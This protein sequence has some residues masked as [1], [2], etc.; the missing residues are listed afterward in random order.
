MF[1]RALQAVSSRHPLAGWVISLLSLTCRAP[2]KCFCATLFLA[3]AFP[4]WPNWEN[5]LGRKEISAK[6]DILQTPLGSADL[7]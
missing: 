1:L 7:I 2:G 4:E 3:Q 5:Y 6:T